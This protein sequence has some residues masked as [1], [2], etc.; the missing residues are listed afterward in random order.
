MDQI[1][2]LL[3]RANAKPSIVRYVERLKTDLKYPDV[4]FKLRSGDTH[5]ASPPC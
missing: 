2:P 1:R 4:L 5:H 3:T